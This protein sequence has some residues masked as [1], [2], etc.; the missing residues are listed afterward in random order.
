MSTT[1]NIGLSEEQRKNVCNFLNVLLADT[2]ALSSKTQVCHWNVEG[3][4]FYSLHK[5]FEDQY[6]QLSNALDD[7]AERMRALGY[8]SPLGL[9]NFAQIAQV[10]DFQTDLG[11]ADMI[12]TLL[13]D[14]EYL[15]SRLREGIDLSNQNKDDGTADFLTARLEEHEKT[16]WI[17]RSSL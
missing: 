12:K 13:A 9:K 16:A 7:I 8:K 15:C 11:P 5:M 6:E 10:Q 1:H 4:D 2:F 14:H 17:L 3:P